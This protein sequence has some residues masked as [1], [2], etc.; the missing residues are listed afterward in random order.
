MENVRIRVPGAPRGTWA[1]ASRPLPSATFDSGDGVFVMAA[2]QA[3]AVYLDRQ[4]GLA[5]DAS[6]PCEGPS[7][8]TGLTQN[9]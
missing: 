9:A 7:A 2:K 5:Y 1:G 6:D 3:R 4:G 8:Y